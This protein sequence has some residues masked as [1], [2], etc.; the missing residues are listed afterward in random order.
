MFCWRKFHSR[1]RLDIEITEIKE[2][3]IKQ[4]VMKKVGGDI[5]KVEEV[6]KGVEEVRKKVEDS[7]G[8]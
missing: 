1:S 2:A 4:Y 7:G 5:E 8:S 6:V 3:P